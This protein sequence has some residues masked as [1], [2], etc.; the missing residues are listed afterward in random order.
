MSPTSPPLDLLSSGNSLLTSS[1][2]FNSL[3]GHAGTT[4]GLSLAYVHSQALI[5]RKGEEE[6]AEPKMLFVTGPG[7]GGAFCALL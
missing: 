1:A 3:L 7:H 5:R 4:G 6:G 2:F